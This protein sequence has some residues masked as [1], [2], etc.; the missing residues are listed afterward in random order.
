VVGNLIEVN[1][2]FGAC[3]TEPRGEAGLYALKNI[4]N[5]CLGSNDRFLPSAHG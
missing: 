5:P 2:P 4:R 3:K 1:S